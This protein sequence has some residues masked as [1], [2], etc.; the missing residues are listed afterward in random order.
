LFCA[1]EYTSGWKRREIDVEMF[2]TGS[3]VGAAMAWITA[4]AWFKRS[5]LVKGELINTVIKYLL[6]AALS[7]ILGLLA[8]T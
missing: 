5:E 8:S 2:I 7:F 1:Q 4:Y 3:L 6:V